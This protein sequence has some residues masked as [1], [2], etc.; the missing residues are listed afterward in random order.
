M[1]IW[2]A[3]ASGKYNNPGDPNTAPL[4]PNFKYWGETVTSSTGEYAFKT[5]LPGAYPADTDWDR[6]P[7]IHFRVLKRGYHE[8]VTQMYFKGEPLND[9]DKILENVPKQM[10]GDVIVDFQ[11]GLNDPA[12]K[13]G[14]FNITILKV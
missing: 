3:C 5:I 6:P 10:R 8:L 9:A 2:Q 11:P 7:H 14:T 1:E 13:T 4:D 12:T